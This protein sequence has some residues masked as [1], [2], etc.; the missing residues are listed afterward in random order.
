MW[1]CWFFRTGFM[2]I[3]LVFQQSILK[4]PGPPEKPKKLRENWAAGRG[5]SSTHAQIPSMQGTQKDDRTSLT[6][7]E[8]LHDFHIFSSFG[9]L[10]LFPPLATEFLPTL[11]VQS[12]GNLHL[13]SAPWC[14]NSL[15]RL[16]SHK[17]HGISNQGHK[18]HK[19]V[20]LKGFMEL[21]EWNTYGIL[22]N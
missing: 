2:M 12:F 16:R 9:W 5:F 15:G 11:K 14:S 7:L 19:K 20:S 8:S 6:Y 17:I 13:S 4:T 1:M 22:C 10:F 3:H 18:R 21:F